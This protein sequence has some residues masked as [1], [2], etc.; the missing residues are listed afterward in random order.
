MFCTWPLNLPSPLLAP[1]ILPTR[2]FLQ[3]SD[4]LGFIL[5]GQ[6]LTGDNYSTWSRFMLMAL[7]AKNK[8][9]FVNGLIKPPSSIDP[10]FP[11]WE[12]YNNMILSWIMNFVAKDITTNIIYAIIAHEVWSNLKDRFAQGNGPQNF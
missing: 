5:V 9:G 4:Q 1:M 11:A 8:I 10:L 2:F 12:C 3:K 6:L 7:R